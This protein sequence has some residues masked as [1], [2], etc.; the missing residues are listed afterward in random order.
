MSQDWIDIAQGKFRSGAFPED[1]TVV[2]PD[3][4][5]PTTTPLKDDK[6]K[7]KTPP[8]ALRSEEVVLVGCMSIP[9]SMDELDDLLPQHF[10]DV[11]NQIIWETMLDLRSKDL[12]PDHVQIKAKIEEKGKTPLVKESYLSYLDE[13]PINAKVREHANIVIARYRQ[14]ELVNLGRSIANNAM[15]PAEDVQMMIEEAERLVSEL[16]HTNKKSTLISIGEVYDEELRTITRAHQTGESATGVPSGFDGIDRLTGGW[17]AGDLVVIAG[18]PGS[19][20]T[21]FVT[22][23]LLNIVSTRLDD[24]GTRFG[25]AFFSLEMPRAQIAVR[26]ACSRSGVASEKVR[27]NKLDSRELARLVN[28]TVA[29]KQFPL[30]IDDTPAISLLELRSRIKT[31]KRQVDAGTSRIACKKLKIVAVDYIQLMKSHA[32]KN[33]NR[34]REIALITSGLK[35]IA[36]TEEVCIIALSQMNRSIEKDKKRRPCLSDLRESGSI[37]A[38]ADAVMFVHRPYVGVDEDSEAPVDRVELVIAKQ[39]NGPTESVALRW[40]GKTT[41]FSDED[42]QPGR[43]VHKSDS[44]AGTGNGF[45]K[46]RNGGKVDYRKQE[47]YDDF[48]IP[49]GLA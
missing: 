46:V 7:N 6:T 29:M 33:E 10:Y 18:R 15:T 35:E 30:W 3:P 23:T 47:D 45:E 39:R 9:E 38:D 26:L 2:V 17:H 12:V 21:S 25:A 44:Y 1:V 19:G 27:F 40:D 20:K 49:E 28:E 36:K 31:L 11:R 22:N 48:D 16:A 24:D 34:D 32:K 37:E 43:Y 14:R 4:G 8:C 13:I 41:T 5:K 42:S